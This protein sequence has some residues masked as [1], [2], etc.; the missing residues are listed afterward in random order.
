MKV[1]K[2]E[3]L[4]LQ[5][6]VL[7][8]GLLS[9]IFVFIFMA[10]FPSMEA[11]G[12]Q[13]LVMEKFDAFPMEFMEAFGLDTAVN[14]NDLSHYTAYTIQ[15]IIMAIAVFAIFLGFDSL[16]LE[17]SQGTIEFL[18]AQPLSRKEI[19]WGKSLSHFLALVE[20]VFIVG[21]L[22]LFSAY[23]FKPVDL[24]S[25]QLL[26]DMLEL[27]AGSLF[28]TSLYFS[29]GLVLGSLLHSASGGLA[30]GL[31][32]LTYLLGVVARIKKELDFM[33]YLSFFDYALPM[34]VV[35]GGLERNYL[36]VGGLLILAF[37]LI[38][39]HRFGRK[40]FRI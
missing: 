10:L 16:V 38:S 22:T 19:F 8:W 5:K 29:L 7:V 37:T 14:F 17:E 20:V 35:R 33:R 27:F 9:G 30:I 36:V 13:E 1:F 24:G 11:S 18:Y 25:R 21:V 26:V 40:N 15:Y 2:F 39:Y 32:F 28:V 6:K 12:I 31:F 23:I 3:F 4:R 34:D